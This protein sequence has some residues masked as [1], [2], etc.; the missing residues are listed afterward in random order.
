[1]LQYALKPLVKSAV[2]L[3]GSAFGLMEALRAPGLRADPAPEFHL[4]ENRLD[5]LQTAIARVAEITNGMESRVAEMVTKTELEARF[6]A[7]TRSIDALKMM[8]G[9]TDELLQRV[10]DGLERNPG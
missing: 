8:V 3:M 4:I 6:E 2:V 1:M 10:L 7:Q 5:S 9:Q